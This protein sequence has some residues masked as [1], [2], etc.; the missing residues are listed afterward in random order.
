MSTSF[1]GYDVTNHVTISSGKLNLTASSTTGVKPIEGSILAYD[2]H[3]SGNYQAL[4]V[5]GYSPSRIFVSRDLNASWA[6]T[7]FD[8]PLRQILFQDN[9]HAG[10]QCEN[11]VR[12]VRWKE[13]YYQ[14]RFLSFSSKTELGK[15]L[16]YVNTQCRFDGL[17]DRRF[18]GMDGEYDQSFSG[19]FTIIAKPEPNGPECIGHFRILGWN[20]ARKNKN[21]I[22]QKERASDRTSAGA[23]VYSIIE[24]SGFKQTWHQIGMNS[25][26]KRKPF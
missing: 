23:N 19:N 7:T 10:Q 11:K 14:S 1:P 15:Y 4:D 17:A 8:P 26:Q 21:E 13:R 25:T 9:W 6:P 2:D 18:Q 12:E 24:T 3:G 22:I 16:S 5:L 20:A